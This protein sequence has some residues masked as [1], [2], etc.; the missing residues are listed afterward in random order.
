MLTLIVGP[1]EEVR[2]AG[3]TK[4]EYAERRH[5]R[6]EFWAFL[7]DKVKFKTKLHSNIT[8]G[9]YSWIGT[10]VGIGGVILVYGIG[11]HDAKIELYIDLDKNIGKKNKVFFDALY[12]NKEAIENAFNGVLELERLNT[13]RASRIA[14]YFNG[15]GYK[16]RD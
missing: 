3:Q 10:G 7:L 14:K 9:M 5:L 13:K 1:S 15:I 2:E 11:Q 4:K 8:P 16:D 6:K 12:K